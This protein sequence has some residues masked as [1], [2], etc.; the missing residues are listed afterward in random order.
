MVPYEVF[1]LL[2][3]LRLALP[4][5]DVCVYFRMAEGTYRQMFTTWVSLLHE[6]LLLVF[7]F[8]SQD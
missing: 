4:L 3:R 5:F 7:P 6:E 1:A 2:T 8:I